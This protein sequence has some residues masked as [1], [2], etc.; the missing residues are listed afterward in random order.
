MGGPEGGA[1]D[2]QQAA[3]CAA[4]Q[5]RAGGQAQRPGR[6]R[7]AKAGPQPDRGGG[8]SGSETKRRRRTERPGHNERGAQ[9]A[10]ASERERRPPPRTGG[11]PG[12]SRSGAV[13]GLPPASTRALPVSYAAQDFPLKDLIRR[14]ASH[15]A[16]GLES[17][18]LLGPY[19][20][21][22][23]P[24]VPGVPPGL[25]A[26]SGAGR[27]PLARKD[28]DASVWQP[29]AVIFACGLCHGL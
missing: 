17:L 11:G 8:R 3:S 24:H 25:P 2:G 23:R 16:S 19:P 21:G 1:H 5:A 28:A 4:C 15:A 12:L 14:F 6:H 13:R 20:A 10:G 7:A 27:G 9:A 22:Y 26:P 18:V 29:F